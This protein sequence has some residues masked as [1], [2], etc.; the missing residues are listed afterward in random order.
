MKK[1]KYRHAELK[2]KQFTTRRKYKNMWLNNQYLLTVN[3]IIE[4]PF[5]MRWC[6]GRKYEVAS[7]FTCGNR[8]CSFSFSI[9]LYGSLYY[10]VFSFRANTWF[11]RTYKAYE[12]NFLK[13]K[14]E[15][16]M[17]KY[18]DF[19]SM[20]ELARFVKYIELDNFFS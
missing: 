7:Y 3:R 10:S 1:K 19:S 18:L 15:N 16:D 2:G 6:K 5:C 12:Y 4:C 8:A 13:S 11:N 17:L 20:E 9:S 14:E